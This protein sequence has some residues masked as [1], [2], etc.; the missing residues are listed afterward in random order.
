[1]GAIFFSPGDSHTKGLLVLLC[2]GLED[3]TE[4]DT[5]PKKGLCPLRLLS[6]M[7]K[8]SLFMPLQA[9][10]P[11]NSCLGGVSL[12]DNKIIWKIKMREVKTK[13][14]LETLIVLWIKWRGMLEIKH[15][16]DVDSIVACQDSSWVYG[17]GR[18]KIA[19]SSPATIDFL[20]QDLG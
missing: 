2:L 12:K 14:Y 1:M 8:L 16:I 6:Q 18:T 5:D 15:L 7:K 19:L 3:F 11:E 10:A 9:V 17:E 20:A 13:Q 4:V